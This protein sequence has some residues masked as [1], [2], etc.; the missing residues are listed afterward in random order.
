[1]P[2]AKS[3]PLKIHSSGFHKINS[4]WTVVTKIYSLKMFGNMNY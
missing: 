2:G 4:H 3:Y 1:M